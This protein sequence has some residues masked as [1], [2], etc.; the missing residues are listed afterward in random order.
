M[1][2]IEFI[3]SERFSDIIQTNPSLKVLDLWKNERLEWEKNAMTLGDFPLSQYNSVQIENYQFPDSATLIYY[4]WVNSVIISFGEVIFKSLVTVRNRNKITSSE[5]I[6]LFTK[7][8]SVVGLSVGFQVVKAVVMS[9]L[10]GRIRI[11]DFDDIEITNLNR[12]D[13]GLLQVG[14]TKTEAAYRWI[15]EQNPFLQVDVFENGITNENL[16]DFLNTENGRVDVLIDECDNLLAKI[17]MRSVAKSLQI[18]VIMHTSDRGMLDIENFKLEDSEFKFSFLKYADL[19]ENDIL[20]EAPLII[21]DI[22]DLENASDRSK[23]S[24]SQIGKTLRSWPQLS[25]DVVSGGGNVASAVRL[26]LLG[27]RIKSQRIFLNPEK[28]LEE[29]N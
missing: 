23:F 16:S 25:E 27:R 8:I 3:S 15:M 4:P 13:S 11:A 22:C 20:K 21:A 14:M 5:Q 28:Y 7:T 18:P 26:I 24:F 9:N 19:S 2:R 1:Q 6:E 29:A 17:Q 10:C 12:L